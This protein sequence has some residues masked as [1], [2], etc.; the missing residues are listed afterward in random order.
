MYDILKDGFVQMYE[1]ICK[2]HGVLKDNV[3]PCAAA[4]VNK[5]YSL[6]HLFC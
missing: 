2:H 5:K 1:K 4:P 6:V 3:F